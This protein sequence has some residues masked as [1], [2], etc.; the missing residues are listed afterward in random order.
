MGWRNVIIIQHAKLTY[1]MN[2]LVVQTRDGINQIPLDDINLLLVST[3][4]AVI[5][6]AL[7]SKLAQKQVKIIFVDD[8]YQPICETVDYYPGARNLVKLTNQFKWP[9]DKKAKLWTAIITAKINNQ[10]NVLNNYHLP[11][12]ELKNA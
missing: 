6:S 9:E 12:Q 4:Q 1:S 5:T 11:S 10:I 7:I 8:Q 2:M 3:T